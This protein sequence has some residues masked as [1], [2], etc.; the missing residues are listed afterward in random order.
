MGD[1]RNI[2]LGRTIVGKGYADQPYIL[3]TDDGTWL[4]SVTL[5][6]LIEGS[7]DQHVATFRSID[8]GCTWEK[9]VRLEQQDTVEN[10]YSVMLKVPGGR[11]YIFY[12]RNSDNVRQI[13]YH[14]DRTKFF[15]RVDSLGHYVFRYSDDHGRS[16]SHD[17]YDIPV[18]EF[19][20][21]RENAFQGRIR[22]FWN[23]GKPFVL[24]GRAYLPLSKVGQMGN[25]F[26]QQSEGALVMSDNLLTEKNPAKI[27]WLTLPDGDVGLRTPPGGGSISEEHSYVTLSDGS[28]CASYRSIDGYSVESYS[29]DGGHTWT[30]PHYKLLASGNPAKNPRAA[31]FIW[32]M[33][34]GR[35]L[36]W[37]HNHGG[38]FI[39]ESFEEHKRPNPFYGRN[40]VWLCG[41]VEK[42][43][44]E[45]K[46]ISWLEPRVFLYD[47]VKSSRI[48]YPDFLEDDGN[49][50]FSETQKSIARV[51]QVP[52]EY[53]E[54][55]FTEVNPVMIAHCSGGTCEMPPLPRF[56]PEFGD[57][58]EQE[59]R[60]ALHFR[61]ELND[62]VPDVWFDAMN[63]SGLGFRVEFTADRRIALQWCEPERRLLI[64]SQVLPQKVSSAEIIIDNGS[65][66]VYFRCNGIFCDGGEERQ[67]GW[68]FYDDY[69]QGLDWAKE[70]RLGKSV[71]NFEIGQEIF[72]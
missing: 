30:T 14:D 41:G 36:Y 6:G 35:Y 54:G 34:D 32:K 19:K 56:R 28:I 1:W 26:Y 61:V 42:D 45:G 31:N 3:K 18:R 12:I 10:S 49:L 55:L 24:D 47:A 46:V 37:F 52:K 62:D 53:I 72:Q 40:P 33:N 4:C 21:D 65:D 60:Q 64:D 27:N 63:S 51:H 16:W 11:I 5:S 44:S 2:R 68:Q 48:S 71:A 58:G 70:I 69:M 17:C 43:T 39:R 9:E 23:V 29:R 22:F 15:T 8:K 67:F 38:H 50:Y 66:I 57:R 59:P 25:G 13:P 20:C 7:K